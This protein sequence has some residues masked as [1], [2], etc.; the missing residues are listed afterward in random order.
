MNHPEARSSLLSLIGAEVMRLD[1]KGRVVIPASFAALGNPLVMVPAIQRGDGEPYWT[2]LLIREVDWERQAERNRD[3]FAWW[4]TYGSVSRVV[5]LDATSRRALI[6]VV[7]R[8]ITGFNP[9][10]N[11]VLR[12]MGRAVQILPYDRWDAETNNGV[13]R[14]TA[15]PRPFTSTRQ[16]SNEFRSVSN[17]RPR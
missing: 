4:N 5:P 11:V 1:H 3:N 2:I 10:D 14:N 8:D 12:G 17:H 16:S 7:Q 13:D 15:A 9:L 6:P